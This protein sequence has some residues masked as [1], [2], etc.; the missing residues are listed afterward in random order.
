[1]STSCRIY[2]YLEIEYKLSYQYLKG[3]SKVIRKAS[4]DNR[5]IAGLC[6]LIWRYGEMYQG[7]N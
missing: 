2:F 3:E 6:Y 4:S 1:M 7:N 5:Q